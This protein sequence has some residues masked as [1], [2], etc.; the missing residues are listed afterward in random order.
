MSNILLTGATRGLGLVIARVL[1]EQGHAVYAVARKISDDLQQLL[2]QHPDRLHFVAVDLQNVNEIKTSVFEQAIG[3]DVPI[4]GLVNNAA[5]AYDDIVTNLNQETLQ[6]MF[7][8]NVFAAMELTKHSIKQM[9]LHQV[10]GSI[11]HVS[12]ICVH[13]GYRG[14]A[15]Y[16]ASKGAI[17]AFSK[18]TAREWGS[19]GI[20]SNCVVAGFMETDMSAELTDDQKE[21]IYKRTALKQAVSIDSVAEAVCFLLSDRSAMMTGQKMFVDAGTI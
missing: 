6:A 18:N 2:D 20:R 4:H 16:G 19:K 9:L 10:S 14:L 11:V 15:M 12:S 13:T 5:L 7:C 8:V 3:F 1:L 21:R 17:E